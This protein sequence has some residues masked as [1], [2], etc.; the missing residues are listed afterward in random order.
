[1]GLSRDGREDAL[2]RRRLD[3]ATAEALI[4]GD[5]GAG[6]DELAGVAAFLEEVRALGEGPPPPP[7]AALARM[8]AGEPEPGTGNVLRLVGDECAPASPPATSDGH[9]GQ[10]GPGWRRPSAGAVARAAVLAV[11]ATAGVTGAAAARLLPEPAQQAVS[12]AIETITPF[13][14]FRVPAASSGDAGEA[15]TR[16]GVP[17]SPGDGDEPLPSAGGPGGQSGDGPGDQPGVGEGAHDQAALDPTMGGDPPG[18]RA[19]PRPDPAVTGGGTTVTPAQGPPARVP[20][21]TRRG[22]AAPGPAAP[23]GRTYTATLRGS[24]GPGPRG[25]PDGAGRASVTVHLGREL[26]C[27]AVTTSAVAPVTSVHLHEA[28][29]TSAQPI[30]SGRAKA[31]DGSPRCFG[32]AREVLTR[33]STDPAGH[34]VEVHNAEFPEGALRGSLSP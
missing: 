34:Y 1:M 19:G 3:D 8:L 14:P 20:A 22:D 9:H 26:L 5:A 13:T 10:A 16:Q 21:T 24:T 6:T 30:V 25:D 17:F 31:G 29:A 27:V 4:A 23:A 12:T 11:V 28:S 7:S 33:V 32:V 18:E 2:G 15:M